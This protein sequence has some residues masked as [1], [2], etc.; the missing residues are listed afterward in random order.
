[1]PAENRHPALSA[2]VTTAYGF[3]LLDLAHV[4]LADLTD[5]AVVRTTLDAVMKRLFD[6]AE[7]EHL[8]VS[9]FSSAL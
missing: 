8:T 6:P 4:R 3:N 7:R 9:A 2:A 1:V 5:P